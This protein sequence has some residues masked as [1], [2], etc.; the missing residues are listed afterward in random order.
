MREW[1]RGLTGWIEPDLL[2]QRR[3][4]REVPDIAAYRLRVS[5]RSRTSSRRRSRA[6]SAIRRASSPPR[7]AAA[8]LIA[9]FDVVEDAAAERMDVRGRGAETRP[10][11]TRCST[12]RSPSRAPGS[13]RCARARPSAGGGAWTDPISG[14]LRS[15]LYSMIAIWIAAATGIA[16]SAPRSPNSVEPNSTEVST[17]NGWTCTARAWIRG[18]ITLFSICW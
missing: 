13:R 1:L 5:T 9:G 4:A 11:S 3:L 6:S 14:G 17:M 12:A 2:L 16:S 18:W 8:A 7:L 10:R 15:A